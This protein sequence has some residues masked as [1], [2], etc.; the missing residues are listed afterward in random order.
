ME[1]EELKKPVT[2]LEVAKLLGAHNDEDFE[3]TTQGRNII[4]R[5]AYQLDNSVSYSAPVPELEGALPVVL[6]FANEADR[7]EFVA[8]VQEA[9]PGLVARKL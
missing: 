4:R 7:D 6:Y 3:W 2:P 9:Q 5:M 8:L 1:L